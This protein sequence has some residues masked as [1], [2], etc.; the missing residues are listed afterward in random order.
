LAAA[1][2]APELL[3][4]D[5]SERLKLL[6]YVSLRDFHERRVTAKAP[7]KCRDQSKKVKTANYFDGLFIGVLGSRAV[8]GS[9]DCVHEQAP[10][11]CQK[12]PVF[13]AHYIKQLLVIGSGIVSDIETKQP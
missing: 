13:A 8:T 4:V 12:R 6:N 11:A 5:F 9:Y 1:R 2:A 7:G 3:K 10:V